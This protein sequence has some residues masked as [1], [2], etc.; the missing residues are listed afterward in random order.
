MVD[1]KRIALRSNLIQQSA[2]TSRLAFI[3]SDNYNEQITMFTIS[4]NHTQSVTYSDT[5]AKLGSAAI[6]KQ[7]VALRPTAHA[8]HLVARS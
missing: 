8:A 3:T 1:S 5:M 7:R 2:R 4:I 6:C